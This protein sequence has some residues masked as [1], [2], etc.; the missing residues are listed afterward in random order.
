MAGAEFPRLSTLRKKL[1]TLGKVIGG[2]LAVWTSRKLWMALIGIGVIVSIY[3]DSVMLL[4][5]FSVPE[6]INVFNY[7]YQ[8]MMAA[9]TGIVFWYI[10]KTPKSEVSD[11]GKKIVEDAIKKDA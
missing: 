11:A 2:L 6:A 3:R 10:G 5:S 8:S 4:W 9:I 1:G 7:M